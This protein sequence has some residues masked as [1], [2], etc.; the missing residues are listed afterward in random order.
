MAG[1]VTGCYLT[2]LFP[3]FL[4]AMS[5]IIAREGLMQTYVD[6]MHTVTG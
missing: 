1:G 4:P 5:T 3:R 6:P 2:L